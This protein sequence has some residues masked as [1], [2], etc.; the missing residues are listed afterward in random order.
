[1]R[2]QPRG[3]TYAAVC[4]HC[5]QTISYGVGP[6]IFKL[7]APWC[8]ENHSAPSN[9]LWVAIGVHNCQKV[10][11]S[12]PQCPWAHRVVEFVT[13]L[14]SSDGFT[15]ILIAVF[16]IHYHSH[17]TLF[18]GMQ[19]DTTEGPVHGIRDCHSI[20]QACKV[21]LWHPGWHCLRQRGAGYVK[22]LIGIL[23]ETGDHCESRIELPS[24]I[25]WPGRVIKAITGPLP[26]DILQLGSEK[27]EWIHSLARICP[28]LPYLR[29][30]WPH[31]VP[32]CW[33]ESTFSIPM[34]KRT[35]RHTFWFGLSGK[36]WE[37]VHV[38]LQTVVHNQFFQAN[39]RKCPQMPYQPGQMV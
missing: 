2:L 39:L 28:K 18:K 31:A 11:R 32:V 22:C 6:D 26:A 16:Y 14:P 3:T 7:W 13:D 34:V 29:V 19:T 12:L 5:P 4:T 8:S 25:K 15:T 38:H 10:Y 27:V 20:V 9:H 30:L 24:P 23:W 36:V 1:M 35:V 21:E 17:K 33:Q 37:S